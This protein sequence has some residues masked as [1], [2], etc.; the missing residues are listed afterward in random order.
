MKLV[1]LLVCLFSIVLAASA[2]EPNPNFNE[3]LDQETPQ[4]QKQEAQ[5]P[6]AK[7]SAGDL[8]KATQNPVASLIS[9][10]LQNFTDFNIGPFGRDR[11]T[12]LQ[13][14]PVV[15][16]QLSENWNLITRTIGALVYQPDVTMSRQGTFGL[17]D[18]N[19]SFFLSPANPGKLIWGAGP[20]FLIPT[21]TDNVLGTGKFSI[22]PS[23]VALVQPGK[24][25]LGVLVSNLFSVA[26]PSDR[27]DV[28]SFTL[29]Y[30]INYNLKKG[31]YL[32][33]APIN[34]ANWNAPRGNV[35]LVP[36]GGGIGRIMRF[37]FQPVNVSVQAYGNV[38][39]PDT[40]PAPTWQLKFQIAFLYPKKP[41]G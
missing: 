30:F 33:S 31:Y 9:V 35:W 24:W 3:E 11:N 17:N 36:V 18:I 10:P 38:K 26:G 25:T 20:T 15:P 40:F 29:Q 8:A 37:G 39:R 12:V 1:V 16:I 13:F 22:G 14:Q 23:V 27:A 28:N 7:A 34:S 41:K 2:Q 21:A 5:K 4:Q 6:D 32:T 19:P